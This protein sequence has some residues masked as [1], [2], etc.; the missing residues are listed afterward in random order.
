MVFLSLSLSHLPLFLMSLSLSHQ[1]VFLVTTNTIFFHSFLAGAHVWKFQP[2]HEEV[3]K[4][5]E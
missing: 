2:S 3:S 5:S 4:V 1:G